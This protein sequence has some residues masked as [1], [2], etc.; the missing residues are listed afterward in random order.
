MYCEPVRPFVAEAGAGLSA[1]QLTDDLLHLSDVAGKR[2]IHTRL[3][4]TVTVQEENAAAALEVMSRWAIN[5]KWLVYLPPTMSPCAAAAEGQ[6][7]EFPSEAFEYYRG[8]GVERVMC[9][10][11]HMGSRA[12]VV[13]CRNKDVARTR[14]GITNSEAGA[15]YTRTGRPFFKDAALEGGLL[16]AVCNALEST[17]FWDEFDTGWAVFDCELMPW[18]LKAQELLR[19]QYAATGAAARE[20]IAAALTAIEFTLSRMAG[21]DETSA[22][23]AVMAERFRQRAMAVDAYTRAY[24]H[25]VWAVDGIADIRLAPFQLLATENE[26]HALKDHR[27]HMDTLRKL[28]EAGSP[29]LMATQWKEVDLEAADSVAEVTR[30]WET[31]TGSGGEGMVVKPL[32]TVKQDGGKLFQ[33]A[34]KV[35]GREYLRI[36]YGPEYTQPEHIE[37]L[38]ARHLGQKRSLALRE[39][40]LGIEALE[41]FVRHEPLRQVHECVFGVLALESEPVDPRL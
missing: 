33:P 23:L 3:R 18:S 21:A 28:C 1:Q 4:N 38:R 35:R 34:I 25:Y 36:I 41:R 39:Y 17:G 32:G 37:R 14:F 10:E 30:W 16:E 27:W 6:Y 15:I 40:V 8:C 11:K 29:I 9:Q 5:P 22:G 12:I 19:T 26:V 20:S 13:T 2:I 24:R 31:L 7:L